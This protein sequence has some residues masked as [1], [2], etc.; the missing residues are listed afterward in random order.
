MRV[1]HRLPL[2]AGLPVCLLLSLSAQAPPAAERA[3]PGNPKTLSPKGGPGA[4]FTMLLR[5]NKPENVADFASLQAAHGQIRARDIFIVNTRFRGSTIGK[6]AEILAGLRSR[7]PCNRVIALNGLGAD[8]RRPGY[9]LALADSAQPWAVMLD[10]ERRDWGQARATN[11]WLSRWKRNFGRSL[12]R[13][14][15]M[16]GRVAR[17]IAPAQSGIRK[18]GA[19]PTFFRD[20]NY[21][22]VARAL[23]RRN[24]RLGLQ[25]GGIQAVATQ[26]A[27][28]KHRAGTK[29]I[30]KTTRRLLRQYRT[31]K[32]KPRNLAIQISFSDEARAKRKLPIRSVNEWRA[33]RCLR[34]GFSAGAGAVLFWASPESMQALFQNDR[35]RKLRHRR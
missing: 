22:K 28:T 27:C 17:G 2:A 14:G 34:A 31:A 29:G 35:F 3:C 19:V 5:I 32:R 8:P 13:L 1:S 7:F 23:D 18:I 25:R 21:G 26:G 30:R 9:A 15:S 6:R 33:A 11:P 10:W 12:K 4:R 20:W 24:R 16:V